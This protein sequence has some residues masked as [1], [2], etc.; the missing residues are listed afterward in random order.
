M[1]V[2]T[3]VYHAAGADEVL[4]LAIALSTGVAYLRAMTD[5]G[6]SVAAAVG[7]I[8]FSLAAGVDLFMTVAKL[9]A[10]RRLWARVAEASG[11]A[12]PVAAIGASAADAK[13]RREA[14][15]AKEAKAA[16]EAEAERR[17]MRESRKSSGGGSRWAWRNGS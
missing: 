14:K 3:T 10:A 15:E 2:D 8:E 11:G 13:A 16:K 4:D 17:R 9:R 5:H 6:L 12:V 7:E 1:T